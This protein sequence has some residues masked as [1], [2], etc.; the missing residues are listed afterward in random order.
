MGLRLFLY[1]GILLIGV[2]IGY[3]EISHRKLLSNLHRLQIAALILLLFIMGIRIGADPKVIGALTTL[4]FQAFV[5][6]ISSIFMSILF[7][8]AYRKLFHFNKRGE[9][10]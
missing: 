8:F 9:K 1:L 10:K 7:V 3:K 6:A 4:G 5:L 2:L